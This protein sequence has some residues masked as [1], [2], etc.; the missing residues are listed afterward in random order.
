MRSKT[1]SQF[2]LT[3]VRMMSVVVVLT[4][5]LVPSGGGATVLVDRIVA[6]VNDEIIRLV[7]LNEKFSPLEQQ[8]RSQGHPSGRE[9]EMIY[10][11]RMEVLNDMIDEKLADQQISEAG[12]MVN[13][14]EIDH[15]VEQVKAIN[16]YTDEEL[17]QA[18][19][20][21]GIDMERYREEIRKQI[22]RNKLVNLKVTS[23]IIITQSDMDAYMSAHPEI[24]GPR[25]QYQLRNIMMAIH[26][27]ADAQNRQS[28]YEKMTAVVEMLDD[29]QLF[30]EVA[31]RY[32]EGPNAVE[33][34]ILGS[35][36]LNDLEDNIADAL[37][38]LEPGQFTPIIETEYGY[39]IFYIEEIIDASPK[40][41]DE[42]ASEIRR[43]LYEQQVNERFQAWIEKL[44]Q[45]AHIKIIY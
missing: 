4:A 26:T 24:Y 18:L 2:C 10:Q 7:E 1:M 5:C 19:A 42:S 44:R 40:T 31:K 45:D 43:K 41:A 28:V 36:T 20:L 21:S 16:R 12:I 34:G 14:S 23:S 39:Q 38:Q 30:A 33:G 37:S 11:K 9:E 6:V 17:R 25:K 27:G 22:L 3:S 29:G 8:I 35:F 15:A 32:S 13:P